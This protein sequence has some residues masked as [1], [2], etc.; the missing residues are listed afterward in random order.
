MTVTAEDKDEWVF[1]S[2]DYE[3]MA[4]DGLCIGSHPAGTSTSCD[5]WR[6]GSGTGQDVAFQSLSG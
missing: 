1:G 2:P 5:M 3:P 6:A 4:G